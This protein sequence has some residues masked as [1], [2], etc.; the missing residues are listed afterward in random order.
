MVILPQVHHCD[1]E[2][3]EWLNFGTFVKFSCIVRIY[4]WFFM[5]CRYHHSDSHANHVIIQSNFTKKCAKYPGE[6]IICNWFLKVYLHLQGA[7]E[8]VSTKGLCSYSVVVP[9][10][11]NLRM[12][13]FRFLPFCNVTL[14]NK[15]YHHPWGVR[16]PVDFEGYP[17]HR[18]V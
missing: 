16:V 9:V 8:L 1:C 7:N 12:R 3:C 18:C 13:S 15:I 14:M 4:A 17:F 10:W 6:I 11:G 2:M 5:H